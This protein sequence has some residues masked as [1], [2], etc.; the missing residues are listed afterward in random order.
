[1]QLNRKITIWMTRFN[2]SDITGE[3]ETVSKLK[4]MFTPK[5]EADSGQ[6]GGTVSKENS[7]SVSRSPS[8]HRRSR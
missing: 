4:F 6:T 8:N 2:C 5:S 7:I 1:M 3:N